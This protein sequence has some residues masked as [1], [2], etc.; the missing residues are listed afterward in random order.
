MPDP[1]DNLMTQGC[2]AS[3]CLLT[4]LITIVIILLMYTMQF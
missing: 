3:G 4:L 1:S 2:D